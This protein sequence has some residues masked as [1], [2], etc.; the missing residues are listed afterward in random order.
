MTRDSNQLSRA[1]WN[2][3]IHNGTP[4]QR[5]RCKKST[6]ASVFNFGAIVKDFLTL[7]MVSLRLQCLL[8]YYFMH[9]MAFRT[10]N[11]GP[12]FHPDFF[13]GC[14]WCFDNMHYDVSYQAIKRLLQTREEFASK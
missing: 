9:N 3:V 2:D 14:Q 4:G 1:F 13:G 5:D 10:M 6:G 12:H 11:T 8:L 7:V